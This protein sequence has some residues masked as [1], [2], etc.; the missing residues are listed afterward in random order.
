M[1][2]QYWRDTHKSLEEIFEKVKKK[3]HPRLEPVSILYTF[4]SD[5]KFDDEDRLVGA[6]ARK[7]S[8]RERDL[9]RF[10]FEICVHEDT[11]NSLGNKSKRQL[12]WHELNHCKVIYETDDTGTETQTPDR[13]KAGRIQIKLVT[14]DVVVTTFRE[15]LDIFGPFP[16]DAK[17]F[18]GIY[19][20]V[21][22]NKK[23]V[24]KKALKPNLLT[25]D[26]D[27]EGGN[28]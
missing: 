21:K 20:Y 10:D 15:E 24:R 11:W 8:N 14:H 23:K 9:Y 5:P 18:L 27:D 4:R 3:Y 22:D 2:L 17:T 7:L 1:P 6:E 25:A 26:N 16:G 28:D 19:T 13:D 12:A